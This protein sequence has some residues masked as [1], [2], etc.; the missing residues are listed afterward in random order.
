MRKLILENYQ[1]PGDLVMLTAAVRDLHTL[2]PGMFLTDVRTS[3]P[4]LWEHSPYVTALDETDP[5]VEVIRCEYPLIHQSN[6]LPYHFIHGFIQYLNYRLGLAMYPTAFKGDI[7]LREEET[8]WISQVHEITGEDTPFW[9]VISGGKYDFTC[10]WWAPDRYQQVVDHFQGKITFVQVGEDHH[11]HPPL[12]NAID[13]RGKT[14]IRQ[15]IRLVYHAVGVLTPVSLPMHLAAAVPVRKD[16]PRSRPC[17]VIAGGREPVT[18]EAYPSH[19]FI[20]TI[21]ALNC[22][23]TGGCW[24]ARVLPLGDGD[25][26]DLPENLCLQPVGFLPK[27]MDMISAKEVISRIERY[28]EGGVIGG[29]NPTSQMEAPKTLAQ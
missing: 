15:L 17:V 5:E 24:R 27:C 8:Q 28:Y 20:H 3:V 25:E 2:Y 6:H 21:G 23:E 13:L 19:Q 4:D 26:K 22:C 10:K 7:H 9:I 16:R 18:W 11:H 29:V 12:T 1:S 14:T